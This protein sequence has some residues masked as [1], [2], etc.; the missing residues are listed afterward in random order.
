MNPYSVVTDSTVE[1]G[2][3]FF[4]FPIPTFPDMQFPIQPKKSV[5][6]E[7]EAYNCIVLTQSCDLEHKKISSV[8]LAEL[9]D[10]P[11]Q[12]AQGDIPGNSDARAKMRKEIAQGK[13]PGFI[14]LP[15]CELEV[16]LPWSVVQLAGIRTVDLDY[17]SRYID[18]SKPTRLRLA[19]PLREYLSQSVGVFFMR[20]GLPDSIDF[21]SFEKGR[22][23]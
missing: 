15:P 2:D 10:W 22:W 19:S 9:I 11:Q 12:E 18:Q 14:L 7:F 5:V 21:R 23:K 3:I 6:T 13:R 4:D 8:L 16:G 17:I 1:Q 20:V